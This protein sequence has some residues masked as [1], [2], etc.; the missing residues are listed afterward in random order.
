[1]CLNVQESNC[2]ADNTVSIHLLPLLA[3]PE[4][5]PD[6]VVGCG[7]MGKFS[8]SVPKLCV[9]GLRTGSSSRLSRQGL[10]QQP[11]WLEVWGEV[12]RRELEKPETLSWFSWYPRGFNPRKA[13]QG[14]QLL[15][16]EENN[17]SAR[18]IEAI[19]EEGSVGRA[20]GDLQECSVSC[21]SRES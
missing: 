1:M 13:G 6:E 8:F 17:Q 15:F 3:E 12:E 10:Q 20:G 19:L 18:E 4:A 11:T 21:R 5:S 7:H 2:L 16:Q 14:L 9:S